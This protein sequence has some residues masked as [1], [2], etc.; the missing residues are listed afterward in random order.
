MIIKSKKQSIVRFIDFCSE[1][2]V[3]YFWK[4]INII[5]KKL[6]NFTKNNSLGSMHA[7]YTIMQEF[8]KL[9]G[10]DEID[11]FHNESPA[12]SDRDSYWNFMFSSKYLKIKN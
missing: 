10:I 9:D 1:F 6:T 12:I 8:G 3:P 11:D 7:I 2:D 5:K 4:Y